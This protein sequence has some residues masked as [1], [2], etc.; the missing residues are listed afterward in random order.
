MDAE[1]LVPAFAKILKQGFGTIAIAT[2]KVL[3]TQ[4]SR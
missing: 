1:E 3:R 2:C 4:N